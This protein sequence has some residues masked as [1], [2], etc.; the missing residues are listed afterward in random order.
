MRGQQTTPQEGVVRHLASRYS[1]R[2]VLRAALGMAGAA[3]LAA[4]GG[5]GDAPPAVGTTPPAGGGGPGPTATGAAVGPATRVV[6]PAVGAPVTATRAVAEGTIPSGVE[7]VPDA[8]LKPP[9]AFRSVAA[10]PGRGGTVR[11]FTILDRAPP[12]PR[13]ENRYWQELEQ[14]LGVTWEPTFAPSA[15]YGEKASA[16][17]A[18]GDLGDLFYINTGAAPALSRP[19]G[20]GAFTDLTPY[21][22]GD[23]AK[24]FPNLSQY[25]PYNQEYIWKNVAVKGK[26]YGV[27]KPRL[28]SGNIPFYRDDWARKLGVDPSRSAEEVSAMLVGFS[29]RDPDGNGQADTFG[30]ARGPGIVGDFTTMFRAPNGWRLNPDGTLTNAI[31]TEEYKQGV[32]FA[33]RLFA[34]DGYHPDAATLSGSQIAGAFKAGKIG[35]HREG[36]VVFWGPRGTREQIKEQTNNPNASIAGLVPPGPDSGKG[37]TY[38][39]EGYWGFTSLPA[40]VGRDRE[41]TKELLRIMDY[42]AAPFGSEEQLFLGHGLEGVHHTLQPN[43]TRVNNERA[44]EMNGLVYLLESEY[45]FYYPGAPGDTERAQQLSKEILAIGI[46]NPTLG[47]SSDTAISKAAE[48]N[49]LGNDRLTSI[50]TGREPLGA[51]DN[52][53]REWRQRGGDQIRKEYE[54]ELKEP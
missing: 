20:Q 31:E 35:M 36:F 37:V 5:G 17:V 19:I 23:A 39:L 26:V 6:T 11:V 53:V 30:W 45:R 28:R 25:P 38:N 16:L 54:Q 51:L 49:Q 13:D 43:G 48:L 41:R 46:E 8:Y 29:K 2:A 40:R 34:A 52:Y 50:V 21:L 44:A 47:L 32:E 10:T 42:L 1:R 27:P 9:P 3:V 15:S 12:K 7:G 22:P 18:S 24:E 33:R 14:R 4:C